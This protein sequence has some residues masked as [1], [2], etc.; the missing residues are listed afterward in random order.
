VDAVERAPAW[1]P[2]G[3]RI[4]YFGRRTASTPSRSSTEGFQKPRSSPSPNPGYYSSIVWSP[5]SKKIAFKDNRLNLWILDLSAEKAEPVKWIQH[6][7]QLL[8]RPQSQ[9]VPDGKWVAYDKLM[10]NF[11]HTVFLYSL[12]ESKSYRSP[13]A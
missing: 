7:L 11:L 5:D 2:D 9:L 10:D 13:T 8:F 1:S 12:A 3:E 4:A 6:L